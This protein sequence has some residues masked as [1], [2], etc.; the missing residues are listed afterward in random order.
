[1]QFE[2]TEWENLIIDGAHVLG[3]HV[4]HKVVHQFAVHGVELAK[5]TKKVN[6][7]AITDPFEV[8]LKHFLDSI[9]SARFIPSSASL[10]DIGSGGGFPGIPLK[11]LMP[12]LAVTLIDGSRKKVNFLRHIIRL[13]QLE[14][15]EAR[16]I[17]AEELSQTPVYA[18][19]F[20]VVISRALS[21]VSPFV[22]MAEPLLADEGI[23]IS[24]KGKLDPKELDALRS[25]VSEKSYKTKLNEQR[26][27]L[28]VEKYQLPVIRSKRSI[29][30]ISHFRQKHSVFTDRE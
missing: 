2:S 14:N 26:Y 28:T 30:I 16:Q 17:R 11:I 24:Y 9:A 1:M 3:I 19:A 5:W 23:M 21:A 12:S 15:I 10:L 29:L 13:L 8:G 18:N 7:T 25:P 27:C 6:L 4:D 20:D 22:K